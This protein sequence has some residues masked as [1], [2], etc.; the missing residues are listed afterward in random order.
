MT[1]AKRKGFSRGGEE[2]EVSKVNNGQI[3]ELGFDPENYEVLFFFFLERFSLVFWGFF[4]YH[5]NDVISIMH[6]C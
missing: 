3:K 4:L 1:L 2:G 6:I 5:A